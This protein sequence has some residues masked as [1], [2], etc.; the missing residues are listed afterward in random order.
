MNYMVCKIL[1]F[2]N[3]YLS[4]CIF[5]L[6]STQCL[7]ELMT[8]DLVFTHNCNIIIS[9]KVEKSDTIWS[10]YYKNIKSTLWRWCHSLLAPIAPAI[11]K[12][13]MH[14]YF[15]LSTRQCLLLQLQSILIARSS[16]NDWLLHMRLSTHVYAKRIQLL[17]ALLR[18]LLEDHGMTTVFSILFHSHLDIHNWTIAINWSI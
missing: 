17:Y 7:T 4:L 18:C 15:Y 11:S 5:Q 14:I 3:F 8:L 9:E 2:Q 13:P 10:P 6:M 1:V 12:S 16:K